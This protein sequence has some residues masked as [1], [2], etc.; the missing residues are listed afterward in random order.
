MLKIF[1]PRTW[2]TKNLAW[3]KALL[4]LLEREITNLKQTK[5]LKNLSIIES[6]EYFLT[7]CPGRI[8]TS[9]LEA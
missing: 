3:Y 4:Y 8:I 5:A 6:S 1:C 9:I 7:S 2:C